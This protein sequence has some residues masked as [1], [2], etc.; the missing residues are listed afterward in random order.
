[1][2]TRLKVSGFKNLVDV[3]VRFGSFTCVAG[4]NGVGKS[5]LFDAIRF[6]SAIADRPLIDAAL[7]VRDEKGKTADVRSLFHRVGD[8]YANEMSFEAEMIIPGEGVD[9]LGQELK[10]SNTFLRY[11]LTLAYRTD[12]KFK[13]F[14]SLEI[15]KEELVP[16]KLSDAKAN[17]LFDHKSTWLKSAIK[18]SGRVSYFISTDE[19]GKERVIK[20]RLEGKTQ[21]LKAVP[22]PRTLLSAVYRANSSTVLLAQREMQSWR[23]LQLEPSALR[24]PDEFTSPTNLDMDGSHLAAT[25]YRLARFNTNYSTTELTEDEAEAQ[26]YSQV[27]NRLAQLINDVRKVGIDRDE[28]RQLLTLI[29][30]AKD[31]TAH[32]ARALSDG[33]LRFLALAVLALDPEAKG[34]L[35]LEEPE[36]GIHP[37][38]IPKILQLLQDI[39]TDVDYPIDKDNPLRQVI[40]NTHSPAVVMQIPDDSLLV[41]ELK[42]TV[43]SGKRFKR[44]S[45][46]CLPDTWRQKAPEAVNVVSKG[47][48]LDYLNPVVIDESEP[49]QHRVVDRPDLQFLI[50]G[51]PTE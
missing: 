37:A 39:A 44:L 41:A 30:T 43:S 21:S 18:V 26:V 45:F 40:I 17:L 47:K 38:R 29:V 33:T 36:N 46:G 28:K 51:S 25:L 50:P 8:E 23:L 7:S 15:L 31:G 3:D 22:L 10:A 42:E 12:D 14:G 4:A 13:S 48:L 19:T 32:P 1:M 9:D 2:L 34:L 5:N 35:C 6:L 49:N 24:Q 11:S 20:I 16:I 27:A